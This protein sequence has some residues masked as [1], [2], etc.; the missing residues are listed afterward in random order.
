[1]FIIQQSDL[2]EKTK[3]TNKQFNWRGGRC[4]CVMQSK[5]SKTAHTKPASTNIKV[6]LH[7][8]LWGMIKTRILAR[9]WVLHGVSERNIKG[10][11]NLRFLKENSSESWCSGWVVFEVPSSPWCWHN[12]RV[13]CKQK[14]SPFAGT[15]SH[16]NMTTS[17]LLATDVGSSKWSVWFLC[18]SRRIK[19]PT[20][21][22]SAQ[23][24]KNPRKIP[25]PS[26]SAGGVWASEVYVTQKTTQNWERTT[27]CKIYDCTERGHI[28]TSLRHYGLV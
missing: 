16:Q 25:T 17:P 22:H 8:L 19:K 15:G 28:V 4:W 27:K 7:R 9:Q 11:N 2:D 1:M 23:K 10:I 20:N 24:G 26:K 21:H 12:T 14:E 3:Q 6:S 13:Y 18:S 5:N